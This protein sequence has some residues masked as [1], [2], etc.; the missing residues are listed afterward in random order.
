MSSCQQI[1]VKSRLRQTYSITR[2]DE[3]ITLPENMAA[4]MYYWK[5][6]PAEPLGAER[7]GVLLNWGKLLVE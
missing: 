4:G 7:D 2:K 3:Q 5:L 6:V 1:F